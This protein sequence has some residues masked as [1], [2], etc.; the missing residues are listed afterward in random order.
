MMNGMDVSPGDG[1]KD[2]SLHEFSANVI[3]N[4][5]DSDVDLTLV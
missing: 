1:A 5:E 2:L 3:G 4:D